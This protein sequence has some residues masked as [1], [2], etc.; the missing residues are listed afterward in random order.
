MKYTLC[1]PLCITDCFIF[2][3]LG[4]LLTRTCY[5]KLFTSRVNRDSHGSF[6]TLQEDLSIKYS[7]LKDILPH[8]SK[9]VVSDAGI[10]L[11]NSFA[12]VVLQAHVL[13]CCFDFDANIEVLLMLMEGLRRKF[14]LHSAKLQVPVLSYENH[15]LRLCIVQMV[16]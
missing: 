7:D 4:Y 5:M 3:K 6:G 16:S 1:I 11:R 15:T 12:Q 13:L 10:T 14:N 8:S 2:L 9:K